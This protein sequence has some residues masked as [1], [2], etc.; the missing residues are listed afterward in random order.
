[1][2]LSLLMDIVK[3]LLYCPKTIT[4]IEKSRKIVIERIKERNSIRP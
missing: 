1:M 3:D 4:I 2:K